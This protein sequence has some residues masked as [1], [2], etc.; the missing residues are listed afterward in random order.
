[1]NPFN[2]ETSQ[3][4]KHI[5]WEILIINVDFLAG[6]SISSDIKGW[7]HSPLLFLSFVSLSYTRHYYYI[8]KIE[9]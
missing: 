1:M 5:L 8:R 4:I 6:A 9:K 3:L 2:I 7:F